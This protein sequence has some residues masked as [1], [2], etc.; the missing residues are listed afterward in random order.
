MNAIELES[1][2]EIKRHC[3]CFDFVFLFFFRVKESRRSGSGVHRVRMQASIE[4]AAMLRIEVRKHFAWIETIFV[5][6]LIR[7]I[8]PFPG[9]SVGSVCFW[10]FKRVQA[11]RCDC[12]IFFSILFAIN[13]SQTW[14]WLSYRARS[15]GEREK[16]IDAI[17]CWFV[18]ITPSS[19]LSAFFFDCISLFLCTF[20]KFIY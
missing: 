20:S 11:K 12:R 13:H 9:V 2:S 17:A 5:F 8:A 19:S 18:M 14:I 6:F 16:K 10:A 1:S 3:E 4:N 15:R 7:F